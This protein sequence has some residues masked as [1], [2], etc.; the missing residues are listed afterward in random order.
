MAEYNDTEQAILDA[1][2]EIFLEKGYKGASTVKIAEKAGVTHAMLHYY[3]R[4]KENIFQKILDKEMMEMLCAVKGTMSTEAGL[5][6]TLE[7]V[8][9]IHF[10]FLN[11]HRRFPF[12]MLNVADS[13]PEMLEKYKKHIEAVVMEE[14]LKHKD[15]M[16]KWIADGE[17][18]DVDPFHLLF[19]IISLNLSAFM[20]LT[21]LQ[22]VLKWDEA[23]V[24]EFLAGR[25]AEIVRTVYLRLYSKI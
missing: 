18:N 14:F 21:I 25:K 3:F 22:N 19:T 20:S 13:N 6:E 16:S 5:W 15:R 23:E 9:N 11:T 24:G 8:I 12:L 7:K 10:D 1:A 17:I 4:S 2:K